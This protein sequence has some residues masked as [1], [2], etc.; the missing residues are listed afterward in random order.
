[1]TI[2]HR[3]TL[4]FTLLVTSLML[5]SGLI[6]WYSLRQIL[7]QALN[8]EIRAKAIKVQEVFDAMVWVHERLAPQQ[9][10]VFDNPA[11]L[12]DLI[13]RESNSAQSGVFMQLSDLSGRIFA[14]TFN[15]GKQELPIHANGSQQEL[16]L[17]SPETGPLDTLYYTQT[18]LVQ[19]KPAAMVQI[20]LPLSERNRLINQMLLGHTLEIL[21]MLAL[22]IMMGQFLSAQALAPVVRMTREV[23]AMGG[24]DLE[25]RVDLRDLS[26]DEIYQLANTFNDLLERI[27]EVFVQ[28][29]QF[30]ADASH[31]MRSPLTVIRGY[32]Q[33]VRKRGREHPELFE[34]SL[35]NVI[36]ETHRLEQ[37]VTD[38]LL[39]ARSR[40]ADR[41]RE[42]FDIVALTRQTVQEF[43]LLHPQL[44]AD[45]PE[46]ALWLEGDAP[47][48]KRVLINLIAN[49]LRAIGPE[50]QVELRCKALGEQL[51]LSV[52]DNGCG[53]DA[54]HL[55]H[56]FDRFYRVDTA[57]N[58]KEGGS[59]LGLAISKE[60]IETH[61]GRIMA[62]SEP[63]QG[64]RF[65]FWLPLSSNEESSTEDSASP[66]DSELF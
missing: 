48:L 12:N 11:I 49:A 28:Q 36:Q 64:S 1:M 5:V 39:L 44:Q 29:E 38:L 33:L 51:E 23:Q 57:R 27:S 16:K 14:R 17:E 47:A 55:P 60:V 52:Q 30:I 56:I 18:I 4:W 20:A 53:I 31:E 19:G 65:V 2:R 35:E 9:P 15:L 41:P 3:I 37:L 8:K 45:L 63:G 13:T 40:A 58:R 66:L 25:Q 59:G 50:G 22:A 7:Y 21:I 34:E 42:L 32:A 46:E 54:A 61:G 62:Q 24:E 10:F 26:P 6:S 43:Q